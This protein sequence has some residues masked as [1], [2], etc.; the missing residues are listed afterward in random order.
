MGVS[1]STRS[2]FNFVIGNFMGTYATGKIVLPSRYG[3]DI[4]SA[5]NNIIQG[6]VIAGCKEC[7]INIYN[8]SD[9]NWIRAN[10]INKSGEGIR[11][12]DVK[13]NALQDNTITD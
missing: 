2:R 7:G 6:N 8:N 12:E 10:H 13:H 9:F 5:F 11:T 4:N 1:L 3:I